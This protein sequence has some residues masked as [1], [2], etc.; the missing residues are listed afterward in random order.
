MADADESRGK[1]VEAEPLQEISGTEGHDFF[2]SP[3]MVVLITE[4]NGTAIDGYQPV[5]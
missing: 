3:V 5:V 1:D 4:N 2:L